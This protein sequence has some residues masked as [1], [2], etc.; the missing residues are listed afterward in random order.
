[1]CLSLHR[2]GGWLP[3]ITGHMTRGSDITGYSQQMGGMHPTGMHSC[4]YI[5]EIEVLCSFLPPTTKL[6]QGNVFTGIC[7]S[8]NRGVSASV[9]AGIPPPPTGADTPKEQMPPQTRHPPR[10]D[11]PGTDPPKQTPPPS[12]Q[13]H[14]Q[15]GN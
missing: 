5:S 8:V 15:G 4:F 6:G 3:S 9:H 1:M 12:L 14:S 10:A 11:P 2:V 13:A 7:D